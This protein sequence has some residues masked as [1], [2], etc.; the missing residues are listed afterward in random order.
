M[1]FTKRP[2]EDKE[3]RY[4]VMK[5]VEVEDLGG[6]AALRQAYLIYFTTLLILYVAMAFFGKLI[7]QTVNALNVVGIQVDASSLQFDNPLWPLRVFL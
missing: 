6:A 2:T 7:V 4:R 5:K 1:R 3:F